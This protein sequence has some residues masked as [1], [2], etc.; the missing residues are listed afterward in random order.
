MSAATLVVVL[1]ASLIA[2]HY[3]GHEALVS[4]TVSRLVHG[5][6]GC[7][8]IKD[9]KHVKLHYFAGRGRGEAMRL[10]MNDY[11]ISYSEMGY[12]R[13]TWPNAKQ[14]G[15]KSGLY[16]FGQVILRYLGRSVGLDCECDELDYCNMIAAGIEDMGKQLSKIMYDPS[17]SVA[18]RDEYLKSTLP[19]WLGYFERLIPSQSTNSQKQSDYIIHGHLTWVDYLLVAALDANIE[20]GQFLLPGDSPDQAKTDVLKPF[21]K[22]AQYYNSMF[23]RPAVID[24]LKSDK[25]YPF[26]LP[27]MPKK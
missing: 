20:F 27:Y 16:L 14:E 2:L 21:P 4:K 22:L 1:I 17:F 18:M 12:T 19:T 9:I 7:F 6:A 23:N 8:P 10:L 11:N 15:L 24:Y 3:T 25:R 13:E 5:K 26:K